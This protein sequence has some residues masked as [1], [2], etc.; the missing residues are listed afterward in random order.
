MSLIPMKKHSTFNLQLPISKGGGRRVHWLLH[1]PRF[2]LYAGVLLAVLAS[3][4][5]AAAQSNTVAGPTDYASFSRFITERNIFDPNR[6]PRNAREGR[7]RNTIRT[8]RT[9]RAAPTFTLVGTMSY[10]KGMFA[11]FDG[12]NADLRKVLSAPASIADYTVAEVTLS[13]VK[14]E[15]ADKKETVQLK[16]GEMMRQEG[17]HWQPAGPGALGA[18]TRETSGGSS[19]PGESSADT[20]SAAAPAAASSASQPDDILK[21]LMQQREQELK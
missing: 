17:G 19:L 10:H 4:S 21:K 9:Q 7:T 14:L 16:I 2:P 1:V 15:S 8:T 20:G 3:A 18:G 6:Y 11:F 5:F 12:N 13:G